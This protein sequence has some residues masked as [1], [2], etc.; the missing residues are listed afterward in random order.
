MSSVTTDSQGGTADSNVVDLTS[1]RSDGSPAVTT[2][3]RVLDSTRAY[4]EES[5]GPAAPQNQI[6]E[7]VT[8]DYLRAIDMAAPPSPKLLEAELLALLNIVIRDENEKIPKGDGRMPMARHLSHWQV[9]QVLLKLHHVIR[10]TPENI[11]VEREYDLLAM[12]VPRGENAGLYDSS[13]DEIRA[14]ARLYNTQ[15]SLA[16]FREMTAILK[17]DAPRRH[18][19]AHPDLIAVADGIFFYG[20]DDRDID[21]DGRTYRFTAKSTH[22]FDPELIFT[23]KTPVRF[24]P[25]AENVVLIHPTDGTEWDVESWIADLYLT[26]GDADYNT[27]HEGMVELIWEILGAMVR[28]H[29]R[30]GKSAWFYSDVGN[31]GKGTLCALMRNLVGS[32]SHTSIPLSE[33]GKD[34]ALEPLVRATAIIVDE[35]DVGIFVDKAANLKAIQTNDVVPISRKYKTP[36]SMQFFGFM[37]QCLNGMPRMKD[38]SESAYRRHLFVPFDK[39]FTGIERRYIK[40]DYLKRRDVLEYVLKRILLMEYYVLS[41]PV[42][43]K[44]VLAE[45]KAWN[46]PVRAFWHEF[47]LQFAWDLLPFPFLYDLFKVWFGL[48][49]PSGT[50]ISRQQFISDLLSVVEADDMWFC[51][52]KDKRIRPGA[53]MDDPE[54][55]IA[56]HELAGWLSPTYMGKDPMLRSKP[57]VAANYRG[58]LRYP[59]PPSQSTDTDTGS[60]SGNTSEDD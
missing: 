44:A 45:Y 60:C 17:E 12:Y 26:D 27:A 37:V 43:T 19:C 41:E 28:P 47:R 54:P 40:D 38:K 59:N 20:G 11:N 58:I 36:V 4:F 18:R 46:D 32:R 3:A 57:H 23:A 9:A 42:A 22:P 49:N 15:L 6:Y 31:N 55:L 48:V 7:V 50:T 25:D 1:R 52:D 16:D 21:L 29:V 53:L 10:I 2:L 5:P 34:F 51:T 30:W 8:R 14:V 13:E 56:K 24:N 35:N 33:M 39:S